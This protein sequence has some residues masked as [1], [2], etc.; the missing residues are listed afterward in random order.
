MGADETAAI[1]VPAEHQRDD[2]YVAVVD[3]EEEE[4]G[5]MWVGWVDMAKE[6][7]EAGVDDSDGGQNNHP[8][9]GGGVLAH[10]NADG[11]KN[12]EA[13]DALDLHGHEGIGA[14]AMRLD[15]HHDCCVKPDG[16][17]HAHEAG[18][19]GEEPA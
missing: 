8:L 2:E 3:V 4:E 6:T 15:V 10:R 1:Q 17:H 5:C 9:V 13:G 11:E 7:A 14:G 12:E 19:C 16:A 18:P